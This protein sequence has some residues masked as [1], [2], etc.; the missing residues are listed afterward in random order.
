MFIQRNQA[1]QIVGV[2][3]VRQPDLAEEEI[4]D[5]HPDV[6][7]FLAPPLKATM[8]L[9]EFKARL[10]SQE[11][12]DLAKLAFSGTLSDADKALMF[13]F[14]TATTLAFGD[15]KFAQGLARLRAL[16]VLKTDERAAEL[17]TP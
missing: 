2:F 5:N 9:S 17:A 3:A 6:V 14:M 10:T 11:K 16:D 13:D 15:P 4:A 7:A 8:T 12:L 1:N